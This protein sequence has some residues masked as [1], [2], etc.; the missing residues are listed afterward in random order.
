MEDIVKN[1]AERFPEKEINESKTIVGRI[2]YVPH[3]GVYHSKKST[4]IRVAFDCSAPY[5]NVSLNDYLLSGA[6]LVSKLIGIICRFRKE[7]VAVMMDIKAMFHEFLVRERDRNLL[8]FLWWEGGDTRKPFVEFRM[9]VHLFGATS[10]PG[11]ANFGLKRAADDGETE[12]GRKIADYV[13]E[14]FYVD[15][16]IT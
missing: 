13:R 10:S 7:E 5:Q 11:C 4:K 6:I 3:T 1:Y 9:K 12:F 15:D 8:R 16:G 14:D 2:N